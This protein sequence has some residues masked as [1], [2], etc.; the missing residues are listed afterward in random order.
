MRKYKACPRD[1]PIKRFSKLVQMADRHSCW[2]FTGARKHNGHGYFWD[3]SKLILAHRYSYEQ[4]FGP[5][6]EGLCI[7]HK[8]D[9]PPCVNPEHLFV[10]TKSDNIKDRDKKGRCYSL[11]NGTLMQ[12]EQLMID[13]AT[14]T[15]LSLQ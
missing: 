8:C 5:I 12:R 10:G 3:G 15:Y 13:K 4:H 7:L 9:N 2:E 6:P 14:D 11:E 1:I